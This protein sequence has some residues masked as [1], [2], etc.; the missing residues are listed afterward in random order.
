VSVEHVYFFVEERSMEE[1]LRPLLP[2]VIGEIGFEIFTYQ[3]KDDLLLRLPD[4]LRG[5]AWIPDTYRLVVLVDRDGDDCVE[6]KARL[7]ASAQEARLVT[8]SN[9][10]GRRWHIASRIAIEELEAW[11]FG[12]WQAVLEA[13]PRAPVNVPARAPFRDPDAIAGGTWERFEQVMQTTG[14]FPGGL[15]KVRAAREIGAR[16]TPGANR[17]SSFRSFLAV[18]NELAA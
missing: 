6:L 4:R 5:Y 11:Y 18:L 7:D 17:S 3:G 2:R 8:R 13:F 1:F 15:E 10:K 16:I 9:A 14:Y 12:D